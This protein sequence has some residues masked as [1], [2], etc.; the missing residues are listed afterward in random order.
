MQKPCR[1]S[2]ESA[3]L[4]KPRLTQVSSKGI[5]ANR[6]LRIGKEPWAQE[7]RPKIYEKDRGEAK[8]P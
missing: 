1:S 2:G 5:M 3:W 8:P 7:S 6:G 4:Q